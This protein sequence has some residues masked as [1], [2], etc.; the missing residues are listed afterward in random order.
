MC[1]GAPDIPQIPERQAARSPAGSAGG[2]LGEK[3]MRRR[4]FAAAMIAPTL[5]APTATTNITGV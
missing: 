3:D 4:G 5:G 2:R 1:V